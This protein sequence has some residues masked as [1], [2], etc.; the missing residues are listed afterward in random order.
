MKF[1][2][3]TGKYGEEFHLN[4]ENIS[5]IKKNDGVE[6]YSKITLFNSE[7]FVKETPEQIVAMIHEVEDTK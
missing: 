4:I 6:V 7:I 1:I 5:Y 3:I 2:K